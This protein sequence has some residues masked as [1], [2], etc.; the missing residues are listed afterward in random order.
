MKKVTIIGIALTI[1]S[2]FVFTGCNSCSKKED[3]QLEKVKVGFEKVKVG[4]LPMVSSLAHFVAKDQ[5]YYEQEGIIIEETQIGTSDLIA[6]NLVSGHINAAIELS[7]TPLLTYAE[8]AATP[9]PV[10]IYSISNIT[11]EN[12]FDGILVKKNSPIKELKDLS[13][14]KV[15]LFPGSTAENFFKTIFKQSCPGVALPELISIPPNTHIQQLEGGHI[16][17]LY[18]YEPQLSIGKVNH[19]LDSICP[20][21]Y[22]LHFSPC[23]I[24][25][26]AVNSSWAEKNPELLKSYLK[27]IDKAIIFIRENPVKAREILVTA[28]GYEPEIAQSMNIMP[29]SLSTEVSGSK[30]HI[31]KYLKALK[32]MNEIN[33]IPDIEN[34]TLE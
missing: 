1:I 29:M 16:D 31:Q 6:N 30:E 15:G 14:K 2:G 28:V 9:N 17:A 10:R 19:K 32:A 26:A 33:V 24:G 5:G 23:P 27:A 18:T 21:I 8:K 13:G 22:A 7:I 3:S 4:Y 12:G 11:V 34:I 25:V 20:S